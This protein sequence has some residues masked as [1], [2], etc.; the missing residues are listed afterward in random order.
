MTDRF[1]DEHRRRFD[2]DYDERRRRF[3]DDDYDQHRRHYDD[4]D[5]DREDHDDDEDPE[6]KAE[7]E[8][9]AV[10]VS[11]EIIETTW[12]CS[13]CGAVNMGREMR[14]NQCGAPK[15]AD[16]KYEVSADGPVVTDAAQLED[17]AAGL[18][19]VCP[20]CE[21]QNRGNNPQCSSCGATVAVEDRKPAKADLEPV[22]NDKNAQPETAAKGSKKILII[23]GVI[24]LAI[25]LFFVLAGRE[26][27]DSVTVKALTWSRVISVE[28]KVLVRGEDWKHDILDD[29]ELREAQIIDC[30]KKDTG[31]TTKVE[32]RDSN[33]QV[34]TQQKCEDRIEDQKNGYA[35]KIKECKDV[36]VFEEVA[37]RKDY[38]RYQ[39]KKWKELK[40]FEAKGQG[41]DNIQW[42]E[43]GEVETDNE[44][45]N[46]QK[47]VYTVSL[48]KSDGSLVDYKT[49]KEDE[50]KK[51]SVGDQY[52]AVFNDFGKSVK[53][54]GEK[55]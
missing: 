9:K 32:K 13:R 37:V 1:N 43:V 27:T 29:K 21:G 16:A 11:E 4:D 6:A 50:Y 17:A 46:V 5:Y 3:D 44:T 36:P 53:S 38:C 7:A 20:Y 41:F 33:G 26:S 35:K 39:V 18:H 14:C 30:Y 25:I 34:I 48:T 47:E 45:R 23:V 55:L 10:V 31:K 51:Y 40:R 52:Q 12:K 42:P 22:A 8:A 2:E 28:H 15:T 19:W 24:V 54:I 49:N